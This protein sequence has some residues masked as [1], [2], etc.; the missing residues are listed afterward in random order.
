MRTPQDQVE[1]LIQ[2]W[3]SHVEACPLCRVRYQLLP[4]CHGAG[5][6][7][8]RCPQEAALEAMIDRARELATRYREARRRIEARERQAAAART[9]AEARARRRARRARHVP[10]RSTDP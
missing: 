4:P 1:L 6:D 3:A 5:L 9:R 8:G 10:S 7:L 2:A